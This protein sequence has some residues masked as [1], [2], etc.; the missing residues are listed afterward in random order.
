MALHLK[1]SENRARRIR[2]HAGIHIERPTKRKRLGTSAPAEIAAADNA[3]SVY[4]KFK[5]E[6]RPQDGMDYSAMV[7]AG[8][9]VQDFTY[10]WFE[11]KWHYLAVVM[12]LRTRRVIGWSFGLRHSSELTLAALMDA[13][14]KEHPPNILHSDQGSEYLSQKHQEVCARLGIILS[15]SKR[16]SPWQNAFMERFFGSFKIELGHL[17]EY[18]DLAHLLEAIALAIHYYNTKRI[19][20]ALGMPPALYAAQIIEGLDNVSEKMGA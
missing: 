5:D 20:T 15:C 4:A 19:H 9:W 16:A 8:A 3:L 1:W 13:L 12:D 7:N 10:L 11:R 14:S 6:E 18:S 17:G 2:R